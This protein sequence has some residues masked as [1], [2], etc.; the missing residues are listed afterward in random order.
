ME[1]TM[2]TNDVIVAKEIGYLRATTE[3]NKTD[4]AELS[5]LVSTHMEKEEKE[6][7]VLDHKM[8]AMGIATTWLIVKDTQTGNWFSNILGLFIPGL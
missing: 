4:M 8:T 5:L 7:K 1:Q 2:N 3:S 6:R